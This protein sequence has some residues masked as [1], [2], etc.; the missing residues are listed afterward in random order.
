M[1]TAGFS[2]MCYKK[3]ITLAYVLRLR[4]LNSSQAFK[5]VQDSSTLR[6]AFNFVSRTYRS[7]I[8]QPNEFPRK[9]SR[10]GPRC[11]DARLSQHYISPK[12]RSCN[13][14]NFCRKKFPGL[15]KTFLTFL[16]NF[17]GCN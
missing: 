17:G 14:S 3:E 15:T 1:C 7:K 16:D 12:I 10:R 13:F 6:F 8:Y 9:Q 4:R 5:K 11:S 2:T